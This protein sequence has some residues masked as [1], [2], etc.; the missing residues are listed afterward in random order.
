MGLY[1]TTRN[2]EDVINAFWADVVDEVNDDGTWSVSHSVLRIEELDADTFEFTE[3]EVGLFTTTS[4]FISGINFSKYYFDD[5]NKE[6]VQSM[7]TIDS[8]SDPNVCCI[9]VE[10]STFSLGINSVE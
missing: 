2:A 3:G 5:N 7:L 8:G 4:T 9:N 10:T 1:I 6:Q